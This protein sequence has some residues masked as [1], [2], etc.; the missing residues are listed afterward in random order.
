ML[1]NVRRNL[2]EALLFGSTLS[3]VMEVRSESGLLCLL[4]I[5]MVGCAKIY[6]NNKILNLWG[7]NLVFCFN[8]NK[9]RSTNAYT[10]FSEYNH[11][12]FGILH[13]FILD[14]DISK[15]QKL[16]ILLLNVNKFASCLIVHVL[17]M[18][19]T[20]ISANAIVNQELPVN[21]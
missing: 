17:Y 13:R 1:P 10:F 6:F 8:F 21:A 15:R 12:T 5:L 19:I 18:Y 16:I 14:T 7:I 11:C 3:S 9:N 20:R 4:F 2:F